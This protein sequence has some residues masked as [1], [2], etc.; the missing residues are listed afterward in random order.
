MTDFSNK[1]IPLVDHDDPK[2]P[3]DLQTVYG[4]PAKR[5]K[6]TEPPVVLSIEVDEANPLVTIPKSTGQII[7]TPTSMN[8]CA[9]PHN[10]LGVSVLP[11]V[12]SSNVASVRD[13]MPRPRA[14]DGS[15]SL[16]V[17]ELITKASANPRVIY[18]IKMMATG[19]ASPTEIA[20][21]GRHTNVLGSTLQ[22]L[23]DTPITNDKNQGI[24]DTV[25]TLPG[26]LDPGK[27]GSQ[28]SNFNKS[29]LYDPQTRELSPPYS[30]P[31]EFEFRNVQSHTDAAVQVDI[32][33]K[34]PE[35]TAIIDHAYNDGVTKP[36]EDQTPNSVS[37][38]NLAVCGRC[39]K[40]VIGATSQGGTVILWYI[41]KLW[42]LT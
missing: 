14:N 24:S 30:P 29:S 25:Q 10:G 9:V 26:T 20:E 38:K 17:G 3:Q 42:L 1:Y 12:A 33:L 40:K 15:N 6:T 22:T 4:R 16:T 13:G 39:G 8:P 5:R 18:L 7:T 34:S 28:T 21:F 35:V 27:G 31:L 23:E 41:R 36:I 32:K 2:T 19:Q 37:C 11:S